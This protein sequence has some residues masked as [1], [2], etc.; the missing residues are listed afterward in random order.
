VTEL[1]QALVMGVSLA[2][3]YIVLSAGL[4]L[5]FGVLDVV[6]FSQGD[7]MTV[8]AY[9]GFAAVTS[10]GLGTMTSM[11]VMVPVLAMLGF[12]LYMFVIRTTERSPSEV[13][14]IATFGVAMLLQGLIRL[15]YGPES[16]A[17]QLDS[18][19]FEVGGVVIPYEAVQ[20]TAVAAV[21]MILLWLFL[22]Y[23]RIGRSVRATADNR[24]AAELSGIN[25]RQMQLVTVVVSSVLSVA[26][27]YM[28]LA[29]YP[30]SPALGFEQIFAAFAVV[31]VAGMGSLA[32][33][34]YAGLILGV[35]T[36]LAATY[37]DSLSASLVPFVVILLV[38]TVRPTGLAGRTA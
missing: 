17:V 3:L 33:I 24:V 13:R 23:S 11:V 4:A 7:F 6:N 2:A 36:N 10:W 31:V 21:V 28:L 27:A 9:V 35:A 38:L 26:G 29:S 12:L 20:R 15:K 30:I 19:S 18:R 1:T 34:V 37:L 5:I 32:G 25:T 8:G 22:E 16:R 14:F